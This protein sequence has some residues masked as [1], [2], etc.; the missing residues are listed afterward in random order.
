MA[1]SLTEGVGSPPW[2]ETGGPQAHLYRPLRRMPGLES[3][4]SD[5]ALE[6]NGQ[7]EIGR[8]R[9]SQAAPRRVQWGSWIQPGLCRKGARP[10]VNTTGLSP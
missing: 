10:P 8:R 2:T 5:V 9:E 7:E 1:A 3:P 4:G 6:E